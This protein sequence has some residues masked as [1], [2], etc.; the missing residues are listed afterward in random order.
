MPGGPKKKKLKTE[1]FAA[2]VDRRDITE[3]MAALELDPTAHI[4]ACID[5]LHADG[6]RLGITPPNPA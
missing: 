2:G 6:E 5:A 4:Q 1:N 3:G